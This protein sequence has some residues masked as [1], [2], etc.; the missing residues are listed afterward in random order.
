MVARRHMRPSQASLRQ[1]H[2]DQGEVSLSEQL[3]VEQQI[4]QRQ[5]AAESQG[6]VVD[7]ADES[8]PTTT[9][10]VKREASHS[11]AAAELSPDEPSVHVSQEEPHDGGARVT[12]ASSAVDG[13][14]LR[15]TRAGVLDNCNPRAEQVW[16]PFIEVGLATCHGLLP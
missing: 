3:T 10:R 13:I 16:D 8:E 15:S 7:L 14:A 5:A 1:R 12:V 4:S 2:R 9:K 11:A 6:D